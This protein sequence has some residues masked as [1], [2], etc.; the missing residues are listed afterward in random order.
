MALWA[1]SG[2]PDLSHAWHL[3]EASKAAG[4]RLD[5]LSLGGLAMVCQ[6]RGLYMLEVKLMQD[7]LVRGAMCAVATNT[8]ALLLAEMGNAGE[9]LRVLS[10]AGREGWFNEVSRRLWAACGGSGNGPVIVAPA[11]QLDPGEAY[12]KELRLLE[13][14][15]ATGIA[16]DP[17]S[18][19]AAIESFGT[20]TL[21]GTSHWLKVAGGAKAKILTKAVQEVP[22][23][24]IALE[25]GTYCGYS[26]ARLATARGH[27]GGACLGGGHKSPAARVV[28]VEVDMAHAAIAQ[29]M[30]MFAGLAHLVEVLTGHSEDV[31]PWV[32]SKLQERVGGPVVGL[33][34]L[35]QRGSRYEAD[36]AAVESAGV[37]VPGAVV[38]ADN[39]LKPGAPMFLWMVSQSDGSYSTEV[40]SVP[41]F[42]MSGVEDWMTVSI[43]RPSSGRQ[44][45]S[46][47]PPL[48]VRLLEWR[49]ERMRARAH[50]PDHGGSGVGFAEWASFAAEMRQSLCAAGL[51]C[52]ATIIA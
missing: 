18:V 51:G 45:M 49:A 5:G 39:V 47:A 4:Q 20:E 38:V 52:D 30:L 9:A 40:M 6:Q 41:E 31:L 17:D 36:L 7:H 12:S 44:A 42:A 3:L 46:R 16:G 13:H 21:P 35:D 43:Y 19:C 37:L 15:L 33:V 8:A 25:V 34:F 2:R 22:E 29:N 27:S 1:F 50:Q 23:G 10:A 24:C 14:V 48:E 28:T 11:P 26:A 32:A